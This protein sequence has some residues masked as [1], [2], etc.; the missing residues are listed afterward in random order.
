[1]MSLLQSALNNSSPPTCAEA[2]SLRSLFIEGWFIRGWQCTMTGG[3]ESTLLLLTLM[4]YGGVGAALFISTGSM[5]I[6][7]VLSVLLAGILFVTLPA[8]A[9]NLVTIALLLTIPAIAY[10]AVNNIRRA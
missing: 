7:V 3:N 8:T 1:M 10:L 2:E 5:L 4:I 9:A 6:P